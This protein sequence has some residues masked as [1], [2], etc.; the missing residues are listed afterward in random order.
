MENGPEQVVTFFATLRLGAV[1]VPVNTAYKG[2]FLRHQLA[3]SGASVIVVQGD[4]AGRVARDRRRKLPDLEAAVVVGGPDVAITAS[5]CT[6]T[7]PS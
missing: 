5:P 4:F 6:T 7:R 3:D 2:E 1:A